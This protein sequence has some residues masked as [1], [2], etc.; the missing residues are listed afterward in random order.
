MH[1]NHENERAAIIPQEL[2]QRLKN[3]EASKRQQGHYDHRPRYK[4]GKYGSKF[5]NILCN[6]PNPGNHK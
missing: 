4:L 6:Q 1:Y 3:I 5:L 2:V